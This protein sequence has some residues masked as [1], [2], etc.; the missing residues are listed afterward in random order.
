MIKSDIRT[1]ND[2]NEKVTELDTS[3]ESRAK[4]RKVV[5]SRAKSCEVVHGHARSCTVVKCQRSNVY[6][7]P[8]PPH[9][10]GGGSGARR[11][12]V[13]LSRRRPLHLAARVRA[14]RRGAE[15]VRR[16]AERRRV[17]RGRVVRRDGAR[18]GRRAV[19]GARQRARRHADARRP[20]RRH[21]RVPGGARHGEGEA[22]AGHSGAY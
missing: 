1:N 10:G 16:D 12:G 6:L 5:R 2:N 4:S 19:R 14:R 9:A 17:A 7:S 13:P 8:P 20:Q 18:Q 21:D 15:R 22:R 3:L 11:R